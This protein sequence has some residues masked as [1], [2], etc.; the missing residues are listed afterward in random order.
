M[1]VLV[2]GVGNIFLRDD[3]FG[4]EVI[5]QLMAHPVPEGAKVVDFGIRGVHLAYELMDGYDALVLVD[6][7][8]HGQVPGTVSLLEPNF[9]TLPESPASGGLLDA[10]GMEPTSVFSLLQSLGE[11]PAK[12]L[13]V[14]C[15]P[16][17]TDDGIGLS[18]PVA[19]AVEPAVELIR[20][21]LAEELGLQVAKEH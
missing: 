17:D 6:A 8:P 2:A 11:T 9:E 10:H 20:T 21:V 16:A 3:G 7:A 1:T 14:A 18:D 15:Q 13:I 12:T 4:V 19:A 5:K